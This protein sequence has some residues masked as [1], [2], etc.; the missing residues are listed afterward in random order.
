[1]LF[2]VRA[3]FR[4]LDNTK[5]ERATS[6]ARQPTIRCTHRPRERER[7]MHLSTYTKVAIVTFEILLR[8]LVGFH[9]H[10]GQDN[11]QGP[12]AHSSTVTASSSTHTNSNSVTYGGDYEAQRHWME[13]TYHLPL[14]EWYY[15]DLHYWGLDYPP[16]TAYVSY[17]CGWVAHHLG[18]MHD[19]ID[20]TNS[21]TGVCEG[22]EDDKQVCPTSAGKVK[23]QQQ[24]RGL[25]VLK[26]LVALHSSRFGFED[27]GGKLYMRFTVLVLDVLVYM[28]AVWVLVA[29]LTSCD[30][31]DNPTTRNKQIW[32]LLVALSQPAIIL[33]DHGHFQYNTVSL[34]LTLWS[35]HFMT[36]Q[37]SSFMGP[38]IGSIMFSLSLNFKQMELYHAPAVFAYLLGRCFRGDGN[39]QQQRSNIQST[40]AKFCSLG[41]TVIITFALLWA[42]FA[43]KD[44][45][46]HLEGI[47]QIIR[48]VFPFHRGLFEGKVSNLWCALSI[49]PFS[50]R[51]RIAPSLLPLLALGVTLMLILPPCWILFSVGKGESAKGLETRDIKSLLW[52]ATSTS[53]A[54]FLASFQ[55]HE[56]GILIALAPMSLLFLDAPRF[57]AWFSIVATWTL[58]P[59]LVIDRLQEAY[60]CCLVIFGCI[61]YA[62]RPTWSQREVEVDLFST[63]Y[64][65]KFIALLSMVA[66]TIL[67]LSEAMFSPPPQLPDLF[68]VLWSFVGCGLFCFSYLTTLWA[69]AKQLN[70]EFT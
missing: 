13:I 56:K 66:M 23:Q 54:F 60:V 39:N 63:Q 51:N 68:P 15:H 53:L 24:H 33:I 48:R 70:P 21:I 57:V 64:G 19:D 22:G 7:A 55:V 29:R 20:D 12:N 5:R 10:S 3:C 17:V 11:Y 65:T 50:I 42:P 58:W 41:F 34:G 47:L 26:D 40:I 14:N 36:R 45:K 49:K 43:V 8:S 35:F 28:S 2:G 44:S 27:A 30:D 38:L 9:P 59:L 69:M 32:M 6:E 18:S 16:L 1:V 37:S 61:H 46:F 62:M 31:A 25:A 67:H 52:G 4:R